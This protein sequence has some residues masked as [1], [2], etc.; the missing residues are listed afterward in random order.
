M[1]DRP[2]NY[3]GASGVSGQPPAQGFV[4]R[5]FRLDRPDADA[6]QFFKRE[7]RLVELSREHCTFQLMAVDTLEGQQ[8]RQP[9][10]LKKAF[11]FGEDVLTVDYELELLTGPSWEGW[12]TSEVSLAFSSPA[13]TGEPICG[14]ADA[15]AGI[16]CRRR[17]AQDGDGMGN[18]RRTRPRCSNRAGWRPAG[19]WS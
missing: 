14:P 16:Y 5:F 10:R 19:V 11:T 13:V 15:A 4:D 9:V 17:R 6:A 3:I 2:W 18:G 12:F 8:G 7:Y 1:L